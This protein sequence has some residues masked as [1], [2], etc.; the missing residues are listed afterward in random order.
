MW[1]CSAICSDS[2]HY[3]VDVG[4]V[5]NSVWFQFFHSSDAT[6]IPRVIS[7]SSSLQP[8]YCSASPAFV[9]GVQP[10]SLRGRWKLPIR[11]WGLFT[12]GVGF[13]LLLKWPLVVW[14]FMWMGTKSRTKLSNHLL[15][16][17]TECK[18]WTKRTCLP[19]SRFFICSCHNLLSRNRD[20]RRT[21]PV[22]ATLCTDVP[23]LQIT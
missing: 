2:H 1:W 8:K 3:R 20:N 7:L 9:S 14:G 4:H 17:S 16:N 19:K 11:V 22:I 6:D 15:D 13:F 12:M 21:H 18:R 23:Y 10:N 5:W